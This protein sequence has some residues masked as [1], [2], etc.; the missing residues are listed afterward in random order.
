MES[1]NELSTKIISIAALVVLGY[2]FFIAVYNQIIVQSGGFFFAIIFG[3]ILV[4]AFVLLS[5]VTK[6]IEI[7]GDIRENFMWSF[8]ELL[9][10]CHVS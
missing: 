2:I 5:L 4:L 9:L 7:T 10:L 8:V 3:G 1:N 6:L